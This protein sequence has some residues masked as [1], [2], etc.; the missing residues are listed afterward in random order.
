M[1]LAE[2]ALGKAAGDNNPEPAASVIRDGILYVALSQ[3]KSTYVCESGAYVALIDT[4]TDKP[5]KV[6]SDPRVSMA[7]G[8]SQLATL[9]LM[10]RVISIFIV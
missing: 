7:S 10:R 4:K 1:T 9:S 3:M 2:Y 8:E 5:I 6:V